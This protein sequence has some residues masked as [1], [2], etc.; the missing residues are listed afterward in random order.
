MFNNKTDVFTEIGSMISTVKYAD[1]KTFALGEYK[2]KVLQTKYQYKSNILAITEDNYDFILSHILQSV[3]RQESL[4]FLD[5]NMDIY[6]GTQS[7]FRRRS[8]RVYN[9]TYTNANIDTD[10]LSLWENAFDIDGLIDMAEYLLEPTWRHYLDEASYMSLHEELVNGLAGLLSYVI[11]DARLKS[12]KFKYILDLITSN[13]IDKLT[14]IFLAS[15]D[16]TQIIWENFISEA[17]DIKRD[18]DIYISLLSKLA[19][20]INNSVLSFDSY[21][22]CSLSEEGTVTYIS[23]LSEYNEAINIAT[24]AIIKNNI[25]YHE[26]TKGR[27]RAINIIINHLEDFSDLN[28]L[29]ELFGYLKK[30]KMN[31]FISCGDFDKLIAKFGAI[32]VERLLKCLQYIVIRKPVGMSYISEYCGLYID[33]TDI[34]ASVDKEILITDKKYIQCNKYNTSKHRLYDAFYE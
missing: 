25:L 9:F 20:D 15:N 13:S 34:N 29:L 19:K 14:N 32:T 3:N 1:L 4:L 21:N 8:Y 5:S 11:S 30:Y 7:F 10:T 2:G 18:L 28:Y 12:N 26:R 23:N 33:A 17:T 6:K 31:I 24:Y 22:V 27:G 16:T